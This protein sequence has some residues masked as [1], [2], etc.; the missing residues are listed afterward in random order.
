MTQIR[1]QKQRQHLLQINRC[2]KCLNYRKYSIAE[3]S[4]KISA[5]WIILDGWS[6]IYVIKS[7]M[8]A[9]INRNAP[10]LTTFS[11]VFVVFRSAS[12]SFGS[13]GSAF[14]VW[15]S[16]EPYKANAIMPSKYSPDV[17]QKTSRHSR[18]RVCKRER[19]NQECLLISFNKSLVT[20]I[21][22]HQTNYIR[23]QDASKWPD[24]IDNGRQ[25][26]H[27]IWCQIQHI[28]TCSG[29]LKTLRAGE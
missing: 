26:A 16:A 24:T 27:I 25:N 23:Y 5:P 12:I 14:H 22:C 21:R 10:I 13:W 4:H 3:N 6:Q 29:R 2:I 19:D 9:L 7:K 17:S 18:N 20:H 1:D 15:I 11:T 28:H 8:I